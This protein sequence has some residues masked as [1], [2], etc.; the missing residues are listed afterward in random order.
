MMKLNVFQQVIVVAALLIVSAI[1]AIGHFIDWRLAGY[2]ALIGPV[3]YIVNILGSKVI[4]LR[5]FRGWVDRT[6]WHSTSQKI[7]RRNHDNSAESRR[8]HAERILD[9]HEN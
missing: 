2:L 7:A 3:L 6:R 4:R 9:D 1:L 5:L 8:D